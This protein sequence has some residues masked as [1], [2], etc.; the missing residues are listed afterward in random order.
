MVPPENENRRTSRRWR[1]L[2]APLLNFHFGGYIRQRE[3]EWRRK[4]RCRHFSD[5]VQKMKP[6]ISR[7]IGLA[8]IINLTSCSC[9]IV[10]NVYEAKS[11]PKISETSFRSAAESA[12][13]KASRSDSQIYRKR[14]VTLTYSPE[15]RIVLHSSFCPTPISLL[16]LGADAR[17]WE[18]RW[19]QIDASLVDWY[20][21]RGTSLKQVEL[22]TLYPNNLEKHNKPALDN[23]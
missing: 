21:K 23:P 8:C 18:S 2:T 17:A 9:A 3:S 15:D 1:H 7:I 20:A 4:G 6:I 11:G 14:G 5:V 16:T 13:L 12:G 19:E 10:H 22:S